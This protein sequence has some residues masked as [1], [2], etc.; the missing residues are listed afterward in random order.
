MEG[1]PGDA[2][3]GAASPAGGIQQAI[4]G[5]E[6]SLRTGRETCTVTLSSLIRY[7]TALPLRDALNVKY[8]LWQC[9]HESHDIYSQ[10]SVVLP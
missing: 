8:C 5:V 10:G 4:R 9:L 2:R 6:A 1:R 7:R 3:A